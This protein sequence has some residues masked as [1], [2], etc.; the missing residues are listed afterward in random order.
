MFVAKFSQLNSEKVNA[1]TNGNKPYI[2]EVVAGFSKGTFINGTI[3]QN[4]DLQ[5]GKLYLCDN[6]TEMYKDTEQVRVQIICSV[7]PLEFMS[8]RKEL[9]APVLKVAVKA[10]AEVEEEVEEEVSFETEVDITA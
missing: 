10:V 1:D 2:G 5:V 8:L 9:G 7:S 3:F 6:I 4:E